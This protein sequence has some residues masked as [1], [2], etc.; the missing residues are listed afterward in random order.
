MIYS[1]IY[2]IF[3]NTHDSIHIIIIIEEIIFY[4]INNKII[5]HSS[6]YFDITIDMIDSYRVYL[7]C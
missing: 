1:S 5:I 3:P 2:F 6:M 7:I 4:Q